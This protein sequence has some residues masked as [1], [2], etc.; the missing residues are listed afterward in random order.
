VVKPAPGPAE[1]ASAATLSEAVTD[2]KRFEELRELGLDRAL[3]IIKLRIDPDHKQFA[4]LIGIQAQIIQTVMTATVR[5]DQGSL[6]PKSEDRYSR[7]LADAKDQARRLGREIAQEPSPE[8][9][10]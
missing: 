2:D 9:A 4:R 10:E 1:R 7:M 8:G 6:R 5:V 3:E